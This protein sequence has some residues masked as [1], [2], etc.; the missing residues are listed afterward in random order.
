MYIYI[1][2]YTYICIYIYISYQGRPA[3]FAPQQVIKA[4][5]EAMQLMVEGDEWELYVPS[6]LGYGDD[7]TEGIPGGA[8]CYSTPE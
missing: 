8:T 3:T 7:G 6:Y 5:T 1:Y 4:W 2:I